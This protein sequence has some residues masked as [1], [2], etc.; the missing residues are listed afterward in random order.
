MLI[1]Y[2]LET[3]GLSPENDQIMDVCAVMTNDD[4]TLT[5]Y[6]FA[7]PVQL[8]I[9]RVPHPSAL[10][11]SGKRIGDY[12]NL[13]AQNRM[14]VMRDFVDWVHERPDGPGPVTF[15]GW[16]TR[17]F[18][19][20]F[21][22]HELWR[23]LRPPYLTTDY[24]R[25]DAMRIVQLATWKHGDTA[26]TVPTTDKGRTTYALAA[27]TSANSV[28]H[29]RQHTANGD[30]VG[31]IRLC[32]LLQD[33][34]PDEWHGQLRFAHPAFTQD[35]LRQHPFFLHA[36]FSFGRPD[37]RPASLIRSDNG[38][39]LTADLGKPP[40]DA[41]HMDDKNV[42]ARYFS[43]H[44][45]LLLPYKQA[46]LP[47]GPPPELVHERSLAFTGA[48]SE[49]VV[50][51]WRSRKARRDEREP[52]PQHDGASLNWTRM[53]A[54]VYDNMMAFAD[55]G[56]S[57]ISGM[58]HIRLQALAWRACLERGE[59]LGYDGGRPRLVVRGELLAP[60]ELGNGKRGPLSIY[61][62]RAEVK[63]MAARVLTDDERER[64]AEYDEWLSMRLL[65]VQA[66]DLAV[67]PF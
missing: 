58:Q 37:V 63:K 65:D 15:L 8:G 7:R 46:L 39:M 52:Q 67:R 3:T 28:R 16:N 21:L 54:E 33:R 35:W 31:M 6:E 5:G 30:V 57:A 34:L 32:E 64:L 29:T 53:S 11:A 62:A 61:G 48:Y 13:A 14:D 66:G 20:R 45:P 47:Y 18:D 56:P 41:E 26:L 10:L 42:P 9:D 2:D 50:S 22:A 12:L 40:V 19:D 49:Q 17:Y 44:A 25:H 38:L 24:G 51:M 43:L 23:A 27:M 60:A 59:D 4:L 1:F 55:G 36:E